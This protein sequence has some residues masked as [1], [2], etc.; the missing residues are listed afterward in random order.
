MGSDICRD[1]CG[2]GQ[3]F[4]GTIVDE[5]NTCGDGWGWGQHMQGQLQMVIN[6]HHMQLSTL[7]YYWNYYLASGKCTCKRHT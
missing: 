4:V 7:Q 3:M 5:T 2:R 1:S 6:V